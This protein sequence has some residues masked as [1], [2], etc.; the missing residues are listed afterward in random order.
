MASVSHIKLTVYPK[1]FIS[2]FNEFITT[3]APDQAQEDLDEIK[4]TLYKM[5]ENHGFI[6]KSSASVAKKTSKTKKD[7]DAPPSPPTSGW[8]LFMKTLS[9]KCKMA[10]TPEKTITCPKS[11]FSFEWNKLKGSPQGL[12]VISAF[13]SAVTAMKASKQ[14]VDQETLNDLAELISLP[15]E[16]APEFKADY[17]NYIKFHKY[18]KDRKVISSKMREF[19]NSDLK[20]ADKTVQSA[21]IEQFFNTYQAEFDQ[22]CSERTSQYNSHQG[23][24][25]E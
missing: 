1:N 18:L 16:R 3:M 5:L 4:S 22:F 10:S 9:H 8:A 23:S 13:N 7:P 14:P 6:G 19:W 25:E 21:N 15:E 20:N 11:S 17:D 12:E 24:P 2:L